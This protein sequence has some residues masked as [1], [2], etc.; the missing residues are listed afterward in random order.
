MTPPLSYVAMG[1]K[2]EERCCELLR[3]FGFLLQITGRSGDGGIDLAGNWCLSSKKI[4]VVLQCK[5]SR[6]KISSSR[7]REL[8]GSCSLSV[9]DALAFIV[10]TTGPTKAALK[11]IFQSEYR[12]GFITV[13][14]TQCQVS[15]IFLN[16]KI[17]QAAP[18]ISIFQSLADKPVILFNQRPVFFDRGV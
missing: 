1:R 9:R 3:E 8:E 4:P 11:R 14:K 2:F 15:R 10:S 17:R 6:H 12:I 13:T 16:P 7:V 5:Q 18:E